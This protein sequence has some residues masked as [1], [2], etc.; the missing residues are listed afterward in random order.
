M[1]IQATCVLA[2]A[3]AITTTAAAAEV[4]NVYSAR[5]YDSDEAL[6]D[7]FTERTGI[8]V[9]VLEG[10]SDQLIERIKREGS[11]SPADIMMTVDAGRLWRAEQEGI[12]EPVESATLESRIPDHLRHPDGLWFGFS[13][14]LRLI[15]YNEDNF[16]PANLERY[17]DLADPAHEGRICVRS[18]SNIYNQSLLAS[19]IEAHGEEEA[20]RWVQGL[21]DN[22]ARP[23]QGGDT[24]Q[25]RGAA[26]GECEIAVANHYYYI[27]LLT[28]DDPDDRAVAEDVGV[29]FPNQDGRGVHANVG[30]AGLVAD[31][32][33]REAA[34]ELL[35]FLA[36]DEAQEIF[37]RG[38][39]EY[40]VVDGVPRNDVLE[41]WGDPVFDDVNVSVFGEH[42]P[43]AVRIADEVGWR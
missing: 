9:K 40:P 25:I 17:E 37:A 35:E 33:N 16:D 28:S 19:M 42:N 11:A 30:G 4:V 32:P 8:R 39:N 43:T 41:S 22:F 27:R 38:N 6:Y 3:L 36:T 23:P 21:V 15:F 34:V 29:I 12:F 14:R 2:A 20:T 31:A 7:A 18:S 24:D 1:R 5:H 10:D 26:A 13:Q